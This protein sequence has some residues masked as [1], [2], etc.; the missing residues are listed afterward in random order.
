MASV[1]DQEPV[2][3]VVSCGLQTVSDLC[4]ERVV[5][6]VEHDADG[7]SS[8]RCQISGQHIGAVAELVGSGKDELA[9]VVT[10]IRG[11][12]HDERNE[13]CRH[14]CEL[15]HLLHRRLCHVPP[16]FRFSTLPRV[17][18]G[19]RVRPRRCDRLMLDSCVLST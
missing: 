13:C 18:I 8:T 15:C 1:A 7:L 16:P 5:Q 17:L 6:V 3:I 19:D 4:E 2:A 12:A 9:S 14:S 11:V 10:D